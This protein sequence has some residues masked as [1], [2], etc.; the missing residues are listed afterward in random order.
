L[1]KEHS[2]SVK[3]YRREIEISHINEYLKIPGKIFLERFE[4]MTSAWAKI[5]MPDGCGVI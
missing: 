3:D 5:G 1:E 4:S 2:R